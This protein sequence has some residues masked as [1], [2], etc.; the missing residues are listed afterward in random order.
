VQTFKAEDGQRV[1][2]FTADGAGRLALKAVITSP[3]LSAPLAYEQQFSRAKA[4]P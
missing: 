2:T 1:N 4:A 3:Q